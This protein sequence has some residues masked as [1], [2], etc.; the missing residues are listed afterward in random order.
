MASATVLPYCPARFNALLSLEEASA[1][2]APRKTDTLPALVALIH[3]AG[4]ADVAGVALLHAHFTMDG[5]ERLVQHGLVRGAQE[6]SLSAWRQRRSRTLLTRTRQGVAA[7]LLPGADDVAVMFGCDKLGAVAPLE[8]SADHAA[9]YRQ[10]LAAVL[11][12]PGFVAAYTHALMAL[13]ASELLSLALLPPASE[14]APRGAQWLLE[15]G[16]DARSL[17]TRA[18]AAG[19]MPDVAAVLDGSHDVVW[20]VAGG[21]G[22]DAYATQRKCNTKNTKC[23]H[24]LQD[25][26]EAYATQRKC[27]IRNTKCRDKVQDGI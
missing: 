3:S 25:G 5:A 10:S 6:P 14:C 18:Y 13:G 4:L 1:A 22:D 15:Q 12:A 19:E 2:F 27:N 9:H 20:V 26:A 16:G 21:D 17:H 7:P 8:F 11:G 23:R 24:K